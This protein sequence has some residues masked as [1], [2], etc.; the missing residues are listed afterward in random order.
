M[1]TVTGPTMGTSGRGQSDQLPGV[2]SNF[3]GDFLENGMP[4]LGFRRM[5]RSLPGDE[6]GEE[7]FHGAGGQAGQRP[8]GA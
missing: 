8:W 4:R 6:G 1:G 2:G 7:G 5:S 3:G